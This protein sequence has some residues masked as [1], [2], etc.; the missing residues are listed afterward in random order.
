MILLY[1]GMRKGEVLALTKSSINADA[2][3]ITVDRTLIFKKNQSEVKQTTKTKAGIRTTPI[4]QPLKEIL[5]SYIETI[6]TDYLF[7]T[8]DGKTMTDT[9]YRHIWSRF[10][11]AMETTDITSH[12]FR[13]NFATIH[14]MQV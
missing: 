7:T 3:Q 1:T 13:H 9:S 14:I 5:F 2:M 8:N 10:C 12:I 4:F 11:K 6:D